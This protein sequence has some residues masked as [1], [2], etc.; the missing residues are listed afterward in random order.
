MNSR[1]AQKRK[2]ESDPMQ[3]IVALMMRDSADRKER[4]ER[5]SRARETECA[6]KATHDELNSRR[7]EIEREERAAADERK[8]QA[9]ERQRQHELALATENSRSQR[10]MFMLLLSGRI[11][12]QPQQQ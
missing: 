2:R 4:D 1:S 11:S 6:E 3:V 9:A 10:E 7:R 5:E 12:Q 8:E